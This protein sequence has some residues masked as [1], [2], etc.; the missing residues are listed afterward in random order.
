MVKSK[1]LQSYTL[2]LVLSLFTNIHTTKAQIVGT[3]AYIQGTSVEIG[4]S[5]LGGFEGS[6]TTIAPAPAGYHGRSGG[7]ALFGFVANPQL[8]NWLGSN[9]D[10]DFFTPGSPENGWGFQIG[11]ATGSSTSKGN[12]STGLQQINGAITGWN[13][14]FNCYTADW[15]GDYTSATDLHFHINYFLQQT[16]LYYTTTVSIT[17]NTSAT[18]PDMYYYRNVDPDNNETVG[19]G[20]TTQN[21]IVSQPGAGCNL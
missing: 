18:I 21:T 12:N 19:A 7:A 11:A 6:N 20:F 8:N 14:T 3:E 9:Y 17:N 1:L 4:I 13:H 5:G 10:G 2:L 16:D 15:E